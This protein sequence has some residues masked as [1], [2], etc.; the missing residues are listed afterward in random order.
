VGSGVRERDAHVGVPDEGGVVVHRPVRR[1]HA[2]V[3]VV[4]ELVEAEVG[5]D[6]E[7]VAD[8]GADIPESRVEDALR[9]GRAGA[10]GVLGRRDAVEHDPAEAQTG[11]LGGGLAQRVAGVLDD[12]GHRRHRRRLR[13][14]LLDE[15]RKDELRR[16]QP[17]LRDEPAHG[18]VSPQP[19]RPRGG[20]PGTHFA[21]LRAEPLR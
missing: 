2:A 17:L 13:G 7:G 9:V 12:A 6:D 21:V 4:G 10:H 15:H 16:V 8:L 11:G 3:P 1:E 14:T 5:H 18:R 20:E 19:A